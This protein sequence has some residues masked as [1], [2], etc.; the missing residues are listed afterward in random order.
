MEHQPGSNQTPRG[1]PG[2]PA[3]SSVLGVVQKDAEPPGRHMRR[4]ADITMAKRNRLGRN[5]Y[6]GKYIIFHAVQWNLWIL[7]CH[8]KR[9]GNQLHHCNITKKKHYST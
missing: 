1:P 6:D 5:T 2:E 8:S 7:I 3:Q 9:L 4:P